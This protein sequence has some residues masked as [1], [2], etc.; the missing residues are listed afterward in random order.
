MTS[1]TF[2]PFGEINHE[3]HEALHATTLVVGSL[4]ML[5]YIHNIAGRVGLGCGVLEVVF[6]FIKKVFD[7]FIF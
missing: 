7:Y 2:A 1:M 5:V 6:F 4:L 3:A